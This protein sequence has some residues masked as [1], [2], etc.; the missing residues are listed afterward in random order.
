MTL[1]DNGNEGEGRGCGIEAGHGRTAWV[2]LSGGVDSAVTAHLLRE[3][4]WLVKGVTM[5]LWDGR[6]GFSG[7][8]GKGCY[9]PGEEERLARARHV[10][11]RQGIEHY[12]VPLQEEY[13]QHVI[14]YFRRE[15]LNGRTPNPCAHC[16]ACVKFGCLPDC[17]RALGGTSDDYFATGHYAQI[18]RD[19][20]TGRWRL[21]RGADESK[22]QSYFLS[23]LS[24]NQLAHTLFPLGN[25]TKERVR[26]MARAQGWGDLADQA[27][28]QDFIEGP[29]YAI[30]FQPGESRPG[31][32]VARD[33][34]V[35]GRHRG[36]IHYTVGQ[37]KGLGLGGGGIPWYVLAVDAE[38]NRVVVGPR[39]ALYS[40]GLVADALHG[41]AWS[42]WPA[43]PV[44]GR[45]QIRQRHAA[46]LATVRV[47][48][49]P[50]GESPQMHVRFDEPQWAIT[51][52]QVAAVY[53][54]DS[55]L[56]SGVIVSSVDDPSI[57]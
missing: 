26:E 29:D 38:H 34:R 11:E 4:G 3:A 56:A 50:T 24:Q 10:A 23:R 5:S 14:E 35:L 1:A 52:G 6:A 54:G 19:A 2:G 17:A 57:P 48:A 22:D 28:S 25:F 43:G 27:E 30:L 49:S 37:R 46:A 7:G 31:D 8:G 51:P 39:E 9:G 21:R 15:Y 40:S 44:R 13:R 18:D 36:L 16:N 47:V 45:V 55:I 53:D 33:G 20:T 42:D 41:V 32:F 12:V